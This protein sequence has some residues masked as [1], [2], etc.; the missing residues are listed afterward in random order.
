MARTGYGMSLRVCF[1]KN[2]PQPQLCGGM[3]VAAK[4]WGVAS[5]RCACASYMN[6]VTGK[7][8]YVTPDFKVKG[9]VKP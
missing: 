5:Q 2:R 1:K 4:S 6:S 3:P 8:D 7:V 9:V